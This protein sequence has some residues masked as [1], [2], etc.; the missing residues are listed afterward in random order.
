MAMPRWYQ[1]DTA[2][3]CRS[4]VGPRHTARMAA[5]LAMVA[6]AAMTAAQFSGCSSEE[7]T[8]CAELRA[9]LQRIT[10]PTNMGTVAWEDIE[11]LQESVSKA[12]QIRSEIAAECD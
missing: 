11:A 6:L 5:R 12:L 4:V 7:K 9:E 1:F 3:N 2:S 8:S 10:P